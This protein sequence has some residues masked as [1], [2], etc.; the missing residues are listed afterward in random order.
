MLGARSCVLGLADAQHGKEPHSRYVSSRRK[1]MRL[2]LMAVMMVPMPSSVRIKSAAACGN[3]QRLDVL[4]R[5]AA[6]TAVT[7]RRQGIG[8]T[9]AN[10]TNSRCSC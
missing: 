5:D 4:R 3:P 8:C 6:V 9:N 10:S 7:A 1:M 2:R